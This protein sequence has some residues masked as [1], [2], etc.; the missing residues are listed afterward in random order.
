MIKLGLLILVSSTLAITPTLAKDKNRFCLTP[1]SIPL[2]NGITQTEK[3]R[4]V[5]DIVAPE[6][7]KFP[8][9][10][11]YNHDK[12]AEA[13]IL[14]DYQ[15]EPLNFLSS[16]R[17]SNLLYYNNH[18]YAQKNDSK[19][20]V[21]LFQLSQES[22]LF[23]E[24]DHK[25]IPSLIPKLSPV[26]DTNQYDANGQLYE[27]LKFNRRT[28]EVTANG[29]I[30]TDTHTGELFY[31]KYTPKQFPFLREVIGYG[32]ENEKSYATY[33]WDWER[34]N[35][36]IIK[37]IDT[38]DNLLRTIGHSKRLKTI[39]LKG[40]HVAY[41]PSPNLGHPN[42]T[43]AY[44]SSQKLITLKYKNEPIVVHKA[45]DLGIFDLTIL[46]GSKK[47]YSIDK[48]LKI[49]EIN[50][51]KHKG[52]FY[53]TEVPRSNVV[54]ASSIKGL[55]IIYPDLTISKNIAEQYLPNLSRYGFNHIKPLTVRG[56]VFMDT[57]LGPYILI[58]KEISGNKPC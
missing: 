13:W 37:P 32:I 18:I 58:D 6:Q 1:V 31:G 7:S 51:F 23:S 33:R 8:I 49:R 24:I 5:S 43:Y 10:F 57:V 30:I 34:N 52:P 36:T 25:N 35:W 15:V 26:I 11:H 56:D 47:L 17:P 12:N 39:F 2:L 22:G 16:L 38:Y 20:E 53:F 9:I 46:V 19:R 28:N 4:F 44:N 21:K 3:W 40:E 27:P 41:T 54:I 55:Y 50:E 45:L 29:K 48:N 14:K 42:N